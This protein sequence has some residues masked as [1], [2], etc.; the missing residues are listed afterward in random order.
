MSAG[1][2]WAVGPE[3][4]QT[5]PVSSTVLPNKQLT[6]NQA[7]S[8]DSYQTKNAQQNTS[9]CKA[10][11]VRLFGLHSSWGETF[12]TP[13]STK[14]EFG[15]H[16]PCSEAVCCIWSTERD[17]LVCIYQAVRQ[18][19]LFNPSSEQFG[20]YSPSSK[21]VW[22]V[23]PK[24][25]DSLVYIAQAVRQFGLYSPSSEQFG[26]YSPSSEQFGLY[27]PSSETVWSV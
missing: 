10:H 6:S 22:S 27:S 12:W 18:F 19:G 1:C 20:L 5:V 25:W 16:G 23:Q 3:T 26:L 17:S 14:W 2:G 21:T 4:T 8:W 24:Q 11:G 7:D 13:W 9:V 15:L